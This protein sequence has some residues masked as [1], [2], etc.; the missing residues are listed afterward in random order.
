MTSITETLVDW[1]WSLTLRMLPD[2]VVRAAGRHMLDATGC[3]IAAQRLRA[4]PFAEA[5]TSSDGPATVIGTTHRHDPGGAAF[6]NGTLVHALDFDDTHAAALVHPSAVVLPAA[7]ACAEASD[8]DLEDLLPAVIAGYESV[9]RIGRAAPHGFHARGFHATSICGVFAAALVASRI[10][11]LTHSQA[12]QAL[13]IAGSF[14]SGS[15]EFLSAGSSTKQIHPGWASMAGIAAAR[16]AAEGAQ[17]PASILEGDLGVYRGFADLRLDAGSVTDDLGSTWEIGRITVKPYP[18][19]QLTHATLD[20][21]AA[22][23]TDVPHGEAETI[24]VHLPEASVPVV[25]EP[26][27][28]K[29]SPRTPYEAKFALP[30]DVAAMLIDGSI[31]VATFAPDRIERPDVVALAERVTVVPYR[32]GPPPAEAPG[33]V[34]IRLTS[35]DVVIGE[36]ESSSGGPTSPLSDEALLEKFHANCGDVSDAD[37]LAKGLLEPRSID[38][39]GDLLA[40]AAPSPPTAR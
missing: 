28:T 27:P 38:D 33:R 17:G 25:A 6:A 2:D 21:V 4:A 31:N 7:F 11:G 36:V 24:E 9:I 3:A 32:F 35:G 40:A 39:L 13:G 5:L 15:L 20:A 22:T 26:R 10:Q 30:W 19:C 1:A 29:V 34:S 12:V 8:S 16:L 37:R 14:A 23:L 18:V